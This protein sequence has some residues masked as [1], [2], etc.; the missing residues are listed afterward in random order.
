MLEELTQAQKSIWLT[1]KYYQGSS[2]NSIFGTAIIEE[3]VDFKKLEEAIK[4]LC[5]TYDN[6]RLR[7]KIV[8]GEVKQ[9]LS[10]EMDFKIDIIN[11]ANLQELEKERQ[12]IIKKPFQIE[13]S[14]LFQFYIF[15]FDN[16]KGAFALNIHH[17]ISDAWTLALACKKIIQIYSNLKQ[18]QE[19]ET[20][21]IYS[22][23]DYINSEKEYMKSEKFQK[24]KKYWEEKFQN[25][26]EVAV[27]PGSKNG[28]EN[29]IK[30]NRKQ[31]T[32]DKKIIEKVKK[33]CKENSISLFNF[34]MAIFSIYI[35]EISNLDEFVIG[36]PILNRTNF[37]EK[38]TLGMF[39]NTAPLKI[40]L[41]G[42][43]DFKTFAKN[44]AIDSLNMLKHQKY[45][46]QT[47][48]EGLRE[49]DNSIPNLYNI[50]LSY[51]I[52]DTTLKEENIKYR[53]DWIFNG[54]CPDNIQIHIYDL[55]DTDNL[56]IAY[57]YRTSI[58]DE[59]DI[60]QLHNRIKYIVKQVISEENIK[61]KD[62]EIV[63]PEEKEKLVIEFNK[64]ELKYNTKETV[65]GL[66]EK[67]VE[68]TPEKIAII[69]NKQ[70]L[71]Y[72]EL[73]EKANMLARVMMEKGV[74][75]QDIIGIMLNRSP[76][77]IIGLIAILKC[78]ATYLPIDPEY[79]AERISY[80]IENSETKIVLINNNTEKYVPENCSKINVQN[81]KIQNKDNLNLK[82]NENSLV[83]LIY[84]SGSTGKPKGV[85]VTNRNL[86]NF[87]KGMKK[88][89]DFAPNKT[90]V[91]VTT[92]CFDIFGL[93]IWCSLTSG[94]T[95]VVA[96]ELEQNMPTLLNKLCLENKVNMIQT[97]PSRYS[98]IFEDS[99]NLRFLDNITEI[100]VGGEA[101]NE[102][103]VF[104]MKKYSKAKIFNVYGPT[105][106]TIWSTIKELT[107][108]DKITIGKPIAN[109]QCYILNKNHKLLPQGVPGEL[110]IGG[111]GVTNGYLKREDLNKEKFI[112]SPFIPNCKIYN[113]N[114]LAYYTEKGEIVHLGRT[115]F[116]VKIRGFRIELGEIENI[117][118]KNKN[119]I[120]AVVVKRQLKN[121][122][123]ILV[124]YYTTNNKNIEVVN[125]LKEALNNELPQYMV[126]QYFVKIDKMPH[127]PNGKIDRKALPEPEIQHVEKEMIKPRNETDEK[128]IK[129]LEKYLNQED[130]SL[131]DSFYELGGDSLVAIN[132]C[133]AFQSEFN[134]QISIKDFLN[135]ITVQ[136]ISDL[137]TKNIKNVEIPIVKHIE[138]ADYY[139][140]LSGQI[141]MYYSSAVSNNSSTL[142]NIPG[143]VIIDG[144]LDDK[145]LEHCF[146]KIIE[147][148]E[149]LRTYFEIQDKQIV[150]KIKKHVDFKLNVLKNIDYKDLD[151]IL[152]EFIKPFNL[153]EAPLFRVQ[154]VEFTNGKSAI[155]LD[156]HHIIADG[157][158]ISILINEI[159]Q[160]YNNKEIKLPELQFTYKD[161]LS[162]SEDKNFYN[163]YKE[164]E[165]YWLKQFAEE[166]P[167]LNMP[168]NN[169]RPAV[170]SFEGARVYKI[171]DNVTYNKILNIS[172]ELNVTPYMILLCT[173]YILLEK[174]TGQEDIIVGSPCIGRELK[175]SQNIIGMFVNTLPLRNKVN[176]NYTV[177]EFL[178]KLKANVIESFRYQIYPFNDLVDKLN[179]KRDPSRN[180]LF[181]TMFI[182]QNEGYENITIN[183][184]KAT[185]HIP[186]IGIS[187]FD[188]SVEAVPLDDNIKL[189]FEY[190]IKL[191]D[192]DFIMDLSENYINILNLIID[193]IKI[194]ISD[195]NILSKKMEQKILYDFNN[196]K[197]D[198]PE[199][200]FSTLFEE[201]VE[202]TP[203]N[204][205]VVF[206][207][208][209]LTYKELN[210]KSNC[211]AY[212][213]RNVQKIKKGNSVGIMV[214]R[215]LEM[216]IAIL[217][218]MKA[219]GVYI[220][221]DPNYP[222]DRINY[223]LEAASASI[224][225]TNKK[226]ENRINYKN[227]I[228]IDLDNKDI[229]TLPN[230]NLINVNNLSDLLYIIFTSG[231]TG[232]PKGV[233][234]T[235][236]T[237]VNFVHYCNDY[238]GYLKNPKNQTI[239][240]ISTMS[241]D[242]F[243]YEALMPLQRGV[244]VV[245]ANE[246]E[247][248]TPKLLNDLM[249]KNHATA[250]QATP[251]VMQIFVNN[252]ESIPY[253]AELKYLT[254]TGEQV[255]I[256]LVKKLKSL[257]NIT[258][259][260][261]Y[262]PTETY[263]CTLTEVK[264]DF[265]TI[266][267][268]FYNDQM[269]ILDKNLKPVPIG[270]TG[271]IYIS[272]DGLAKGYLNNPELT[273]KSFIEN[274]F[275]ENTLMYKSGDLGKYL[276]N[277]DIIC[278]GRL[279]NQIKIRGLRIELG[280][281][282]T[283]IS[284]YPNIEKVAVL[285]QS[286]N[287]REFISA[288]Y[289]ANKR[290]SINELRKFLAKSLPRYM[291]PSYY[292]PL[293]EFEYTPNGK[294]DRK[295]LTLPKGLSNMRNEEYVSPKTE[296][297]KKLVKIF[298]NVLNTKPIGIH[299][300]FFEL[301]GDS[302]LAMKLNIELL[303][304][305]NKISYSDIFKFATVY[306]IEEK[307]KSSDENEM[308]NK[309][310]DIPESSLKIL[311]N[312][313][314]EVEIQEYHPNN[315]LLTG[316]TGYLGIHILEELLKNEKGK[317]YCIIRKEPGL[318]IT[319]KITQ[320]LNYYFGEKYND[321]IN[322]RIILVNGDIC[323]PN[324]GLKPEELQELINDIDLVINSAANVAHF[325]IYEKFYNTN[326][327]SVKYIV[328][329]CKEYNKRF[330]QIS[331]TGVSGKKIN[332]NY[333]KKESNKEF[334]ES[335]LYIG[336]FL[337]NVYTY[338]KFEA[339]TIVLDAIAHNVDAYIL[340]LGNL[341]PRFSD[342]IF[343]ENIQENA[344]MTKINA[345]MELGM[346][347]EYLLKGPLEFTPVD[348]AA[349]A[350]YKLITNSSDSNRIFH[351]YNHNMVTLDNY[352]KIIKT[353]GYDIKVVSE[354]IFKKDILKILQS[355]D[356]K[357]NLQ[358]IVSDL[359][360]NYHLNYNS[361]II[362]N[363]DFTIKYLKK[364]RFDWPKIS[365]E[366][367]INFIK[368]IRK[369]I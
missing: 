52:T 343:Q 278:L 129:I 126:P 244:K 181:D 270:V 83:Y 258:I 276:K 283:L 355:E 363:S 232:K 336:Q 23:M 149:S 101:V 145:L 6:F 16:G 326:V 193:N 134:V 318:S 68:K 344:F 41:E 174:Y 253:L 354:D 153:H 180:L 31:F 72:K 171:I 316:V 107:K 338:T 88:E 124:A 175:E 313:T 224:L 78:G 191:F 364:C 320:K 204:I 358:N 260:N 353:F 254:L 122:H 105:E 275:I 347:P 179:I 67:Q 248:T 280:E 249:I 236:R 367:L 167:V 218:V 289:V 186:D 239:V 104:N 81:I 230:T 21:T 185:Y 299:D 110:Y 97:T 345:F 113:T 125:E 293:D 109:T 311:E 297:Q 87:I 170:Q 282:E 301:G 329:F 228:T 146:C 132:V 216:I 361:D 272:G 233:M 141:R 165:E 18:N 148:H 24:D 257:G 51:Q 130:I 250:T 155:F 357:T 135:C 220:P 131:A 359:D 208:K 10:K 201:Q 251:S 121:G 300:N 14:K 144:L 65:I 137:I 222:E 267:K 322:K 291:V 252:I 213:L 73:N 172:K 274:P 76:E 189:T 80:M 332:P 196:T 285:K 140:L 255:P 265:I 366:Y 93:E 259:Y 28:I 307:I 245:I 273:A 339:E 90:M 156:V 176:N 205:A 212:Y 91:S 235:Q 315:I 22:Y 261:G 288:Y 284:K 26:P 238:V 314:K 45:S 44:I 42:I 215:S 337:D 117:I 63:T 9:E 100:L 5:Q 138:K 350:I 199:K 368:L 48:L 225:L 94:L 4:I 360:N 82:I 227:K 158:S 369:G 99:T 95:L 323:K 335:S 231:S 7:L 242:I 269:Y 303:E 162:L 348:V 85:Q 40:N 79:P 34:F 195:I 2:V 59:K 19:I 362:L 247:Q 119:I 89:I 182:Y 102:K 152:K 35:S 263:Y 268:P 349:Q 327:K 217:G 351:V 142:Y 295:K 312:T 256:T 187:K 37:K 43:E 243:T 237:F 53:T 92:I 96:N 133:T 190:A 202:K 74:K 157:K 150:Q 330:Y 356:K 1:E 38:D 305:T 55:N 69:S 221:I 209:Q 86:N 159:C 264:D 84:T 240:S 234:Q 33:Y 61:I 111:D 36:T 279:D 219:G 58:Y 39:I 106:T 281:I 112:K 178:E 188:L 331:T 192:E 12:K 310:E 203:N 194:G 324:F 198:Y 341:M 177:L 328:D 200:T 183:N 62:I 66:F 54:Y 60:E 298:E 46:Y 206:E 8:N 13:N 120:Q 304:F 11:V 271:E 210:E 56:D 333:N 70:K 77:M 3:K 160:L 17:I 27:I 173:Y 15:K 29:D 166:F 161:F 340:R 116:Q 306:E 164:A 127:T 346:I 147:R 207:D 139:P 151:N 352:L 20:K 64:T 365:E 47:I 57:D 71:T 246:N 169:I 223:M 32:I 266:G 229:Y 294:I 319:R 154:Y 143:A 103:I 286:I 98:V 317:V 334:Y 136:E 118:E 302:L 296:L 163:E 287:N 292:I 241:F 108:E 321:L 50:L 75:Q 309:I 49:K 277:G 308:H 25:I 30:G 128:I 214:N 342:G 197:S 226:I 123:D 290:I 262:G 114:D 184:F 115:D 325:G 168:T 211:L